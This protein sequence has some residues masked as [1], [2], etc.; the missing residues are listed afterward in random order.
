[1]GAGDK[2]DVA[3][4]WRDG[5]QIVRD[6]YT[7]D[8]IEAFRRD[9][10]ESRGH[11]GDLLSN[12]RM[13][14]AL[15]DGRMVDVARK[16]LGSD[17]IVYA[18]DSSFTINSK[19]H[20]FHKD[21]ADRNDAKAPDWQSR[22]TILRFGIYLQDH[23]KYTGGLN[24]R[25]GSHE[26]AS[27]QTGKNVY[28][29]N[30]LGD[31][32]VWSLRM[33]HSGNGDLRLWPNWG[34]DPKPTRRMGQHP[35]WWR[36]APSPGDR[37]AVFAALGLD[38]AHHHRYVDYL[39]T[40]TYICRIWGKS[41]YEDEAIAEAKEGGLTVRDVPREIVGDDTVGKNEKWTAIPY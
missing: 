20:G 39:K 18:G 28:V 8:E 41:Q 11:G 38:D 30:R 37:M 27:L 7:A 24:L 6:V 16:L 13:R 4:F 33:T 17:E 36:V 26:Q 12:P 40:R 25:V 19:Q 32:V 2:V 14:R 23:E 22:Y 34:G 1:M 29:R 35:F 10:K 5:Y 31:L 21:N 15:T 3:A 9:A